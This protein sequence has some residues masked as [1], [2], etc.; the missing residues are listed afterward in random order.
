[1]NVREIVNSLVV[2]RNRITAAISAL[3]TQNGSAS[4][5]G[6]RGP[7]HL[8]AEAR[9]RIAAAQRRRWAARKHEASSVSGS[10]SS[11]AGKRGPRRLSAEARQ[12]IAAAQRARW[13]KRREQGKKK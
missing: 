10:S 4:R 12:K 9:A 5:S 11:Q 3:Q 7:R 2:E 1:M 6:R 13:A 8:S